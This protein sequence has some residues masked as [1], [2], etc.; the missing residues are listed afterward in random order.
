MAIAAGYPPWQRI[1]TYQTY[2]GRADKKN[3]GGLAAVNGQTDIDVSEFQALA[4]DTA[5]NQR[6]APWAVLQVTLNDSTTSN[7]TLV[8]YWDMANA[9]APVSIVRNADNDFTITWETSPTGPL[10]TTGLLNI[11]GARAT[12]SGTTGAACTDELVDTNADGY[13]EAVRIRAFAVSA[14]VNDPTITIVVY[15]GQAV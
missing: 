10:E 8:N 14:A 9:A 15:S 12:V 7:P 4:R 6:T 13:S 3:L 11:I 1:N 2:G 5:A